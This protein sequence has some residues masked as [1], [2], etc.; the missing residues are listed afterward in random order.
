MNLDTTTSRASVP[1]VSAATGEAIDSLGEHSQSILGYRFGLGEFSF[2]VSGLIAAA[3]VLLLVWVF[4]RVMQ[5]G[6]TR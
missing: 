1:D 3:I 2:S 6:F 5:K 4:S